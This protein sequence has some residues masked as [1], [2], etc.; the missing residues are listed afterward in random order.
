MDQEQV[1]TGTWVEHERF[2]QK[3]VGGQVRQVKPEGLMP[4]WVRHRPRTGRW[5]A[6]RD[7]EKSGDPM[8]DQSKHGLKMWTKV[9]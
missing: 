3:Q 7:G 2:T 5:T 1:K 9:R 4:Y 8:A 6:K